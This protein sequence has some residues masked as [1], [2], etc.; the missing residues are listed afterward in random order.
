MR[1]WS[2]KKKT[3]L[4]LNTFDEFWLAITNS[5]SKTSDIVDAVNRLPNSEQVF[6]D[7][8]QVVGL[9]L[10]H[11]AALFKRY[12][13]VDALLNKNSSADAV[14]IYGQKPSD[15]VPGGEKKI[16]KR[17]RSAENNE[18]SIQPI[19]FAK[20]YEKTTTFESLQFA[21]KHGLD[22][23]V[24]LILEFHLLKLNEHQLEIALHDC[25]TVSRINAYCMLMQYALRIHLHDK[26]AAANIHERIRYQ[27]GFNS[28]HE[29]S[30][31]AVLK[32]VS[33]T[34]ENRLSPPNKPR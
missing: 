8:D 17:L 5:E 1:F 28:I 31:E 15:L 34:R 25:A 19:I 21:I 11:F 16:L 22:H 13:L 18:V 4:N 30:F 32:P 23:N 10:L 7:C 2:R 33:L 3:Y 14:S 26:Q 29:L 6:F 12:E 20:P 27:H 9:T 24:R